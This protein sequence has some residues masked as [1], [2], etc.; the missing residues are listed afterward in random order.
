M[1]IFANRL[2][3]LRGMNSQS[4]AAQRIHTSQQN[5]ARY[6]SG[7]VL[8]SI[9]VLHQI[10]EEFNVSADWLLGL[11]D[12]KKGVVLHTP[13]PRESARIADLEAKVQQLQGENTG[14]RYALNALGK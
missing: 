4:I 13:D 9:K 6:E 1:K 12:N 10:C 14:L 8:P 11:T 2:S 5:W 7:G 3:E